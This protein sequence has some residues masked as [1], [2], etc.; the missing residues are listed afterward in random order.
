M[1]EQEQRCRPQQEQ[2][3]LPQP[4]PQRSQRRRR[5]RATPG[6]QAAREGSFARTH[7]ETRTWPHERRTGAQIGL[8]KGLLATRGQDGEAQLQVGR[9]RFRHT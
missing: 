7:T 9:R 3:R 4:G 1:G 6:H 5:H 2:R 8:V